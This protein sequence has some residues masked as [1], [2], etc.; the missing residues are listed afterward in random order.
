MDVKLIFKG[1]VVGIGK[2]I[3]GVSGAMLAMFM[4]IYEDLMEAI[5]H[6]FDDKKRHFWFLLS[7]G[8][9]LFLAIVLFSKIILFLLNHYY[10]YTMYL[11][12]GLITGTVFSFSKNIQIKKKNLLVGFFA[13]LVLFAFSFLPSGN[14]YHFQGGLLHYFYTI[15]L[16]MIDAFT[17]IVPGISGTA[18]FM[19]L[20]SYEFVLSILG[21]PF[22]F[23]FCL[24]A[25]GLV[26]GVIFTCYLMYYLLKKKKELVNSVIMG[27]AA[28]S[29]ILLLLSLSRSMNLL[30]FVIFMIGTF[31]GF[32]CDN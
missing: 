3:P 24:Y 25:I 19:M 15:A 1:F 22:S 9:G 4:G 17:S 30:F 13:F 14:L 5:T 27:F 6:F 11:F 26:L 2:I 29:I 10:Y 18:I 21:S 8:I 20:G 7:F 16:G 32:L 23:L 31:L 28:A 12:L